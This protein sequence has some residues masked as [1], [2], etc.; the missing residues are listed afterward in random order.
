MVREG[1]SK[2]MANMLL[3]DFKRVIKHF[4]T[5]KSYKPTVKKFKGKVIKH[6]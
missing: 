4:E 5:Q 6:C 1:F 2:D 3:D